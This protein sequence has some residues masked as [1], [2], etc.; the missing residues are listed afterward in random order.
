MSNECSKAIARRLREP[1][2]ATR[3][4][5]GDG[6]D[7]GSG[8][9][10]LGNVDFLGNYKHLFP[11]MTGCRSWDVEDGDAQTMAGVPDESFDFVH[12]AH[13]LEH[14]SRPWE[15]LNNWWRI[16]RAGGS[17]V[18]IVPDAYLY[19]HGQWPSQFNGDHKKRF[20]VLKSFERDRGDDFICVVSLLSPLDPVPYVKKIEL[21]DATYDY[22]AD[23]AVDQTGGIAECAIEFILRKP[24]V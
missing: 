9:P 15:A 8:S 5:V 2:F 24:L 10:H 12:S 19:E 13:C 7:I 22:A 20:T 21:L 18:V 6:I 14:M 17:M 23:P 1:N 3:Y 4:F 11:L 16:L